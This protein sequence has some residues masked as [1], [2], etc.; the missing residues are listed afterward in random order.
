[1]IEEVVALVLFVGVVLYACFGGADFGVGIWDLTAGGDTKGG[2]MRSLVDRS[3]GPVWEANH[4]WL[5]FVLVYLW[6]G[7]PIAFASIAETLWVPLSLAGLGIVLRGAAFAFRKFSPTIATARF[8]GV[9]FATSS[10]ITPFFFGAVVGAIASGRVPVDRSGNQMTSWISATSIVGGVM[11]VVTC[12]FLAAVLLAVEAD[13]SQDD[14]LT[15]TCRRNALIA[16]VVAG[17]V[18]LVSLAP[19]HD[20]AP[21]F[22]ERLTG[23]ALPVVIASAVAGGF[24]L[25]SLW[26]R[27]LRTA[28]ATALLAVALVVF[29][30]GVAQWPYLIMDVITV[31]DAATVH[32]TLWAL[33][34]VF[35]FAIVTVVPS[36]MYLYWVTQQRSWVESEH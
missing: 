23:R 10:V 36:L 5:I 3:I 28:R 13:R 4:V 27:W 20:D 15:A 29:G 25:F 26:K 30:W 14:T 35:G 1:M 24:T 32:A 12:A 6:T 16:A 9:L 19:L 2:A 31:Q 8:Y 11:A 33:L 34:G 17:F 22:F 18:V 7:F 21:H